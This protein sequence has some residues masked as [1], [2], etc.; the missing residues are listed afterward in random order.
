MGPLWN[1]GGGGLA[2]NTKNCN[3]RSLVRRLADGELGLKEVSC[4]KRFRVDPKEHLI[5][6]VYS[7]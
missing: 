5:S 3:V 6:Q 2:N 1:G 7:H 4:D